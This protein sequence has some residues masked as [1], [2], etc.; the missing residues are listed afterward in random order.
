MRAFSPVKII[1]LAVLVVTAAGCTMCPDCDIDSYGAYGGRWQRTQRN[2]GRVA[3]LFDPAGA[4]VP[5]GYT[6]ST[7][8]NSVMQEPETEGGD[9]SA[10]AMDSDSDTDS[11]VQ[12]AAYFE[13]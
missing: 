10:E 11:M 3:S 5:Y 7:A 9:D 13:D 4:Q 8:P 1:G 12:E 6:E 2:S